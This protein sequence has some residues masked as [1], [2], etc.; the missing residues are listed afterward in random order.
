MSEKPFFQQAARALLKSSKFEPCLSAGICPGNASRR[1]H[2]NSRA[3]QLE[4]KLHLLIDLQRSNGLNSNSAFG[5][6]AN[7]A[8]ITLTDIDVRQ[9]VD[10][11]AMMLPFA[12]QRNCSRC[13]VGGGNEIRPI[14]HD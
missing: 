10:L 9:A 4:S 1:F 6:V 14:L 2:A 13:G 11:M 8:A 7:N 12:A 5:E 3:H